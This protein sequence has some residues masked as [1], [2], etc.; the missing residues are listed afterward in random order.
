MARL[1]EAEEVAQAVLFLASHAASGMTT[2]EIVLD[3]GTIDAPFGAPV[4]R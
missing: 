4:Y 3:G 2:S 1:S